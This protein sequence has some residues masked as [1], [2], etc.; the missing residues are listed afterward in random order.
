ACFRFGSSIQKV[1]ATVGDGPVSP[2]ADAGLIRHD[3]RL[4]TATCRDTPDARLIELREVES[5]AVGGFKAGEATV[6]RHLRF[7]AIRES[8]PPKLPVSGAFG[9]AVDGPAIPRPA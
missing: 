3:E 5:S 9:G 1:E 8:V 4:G 6:R 2:V 7:C